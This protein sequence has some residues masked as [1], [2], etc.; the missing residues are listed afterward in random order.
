MYSDWRSTEW[1]G[2]RSDDLVDEDPDEQ[3]YI[4]ELGHRTFVVAVGKMAFV[5]LLGLFIPLF[6][7]LGL[8]RTRR[9]RDTPPSTIETH[10]RAEFIVYRLMS[11]RR[12]RVPT[13]LHSPLLWD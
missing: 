8:V 10:H 6:L 4:G 9:K 5:I 1:S 2:I 3:E 12:L 11:Y 13:S 7:S